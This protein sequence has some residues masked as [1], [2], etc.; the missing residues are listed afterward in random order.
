MERTEAD[1]AN[2]RLCWNVNKERLANAPGF[3]K[4]NWPRMADPQ[5]GLD[6]HRYFPGSAVLGVSVLRSPPPSAER[7]RSPA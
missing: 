6:V 3:D 2:Q 7:A 1:T 5:W 4:D